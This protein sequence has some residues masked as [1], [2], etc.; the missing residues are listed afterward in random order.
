MSEDSQD[1]SAP[2]GP[3]RPEGETPAQPAMPA[4]QGES[5]AAKPAPQPAGE[6]SGA[7]PVPAAAGDAA[8]KPA[9]PAPASPTADT[10]SSE[11]AAPAPAPRPRPAPPAAGA[12]AAAAPAAPAAAGEAAAPR[13]PRAPAGPS[14]AELA[15]RAE[16]PS[17][18]LD[19]LRAKFP[20]IAKSATFFAGVPIVEVPAASIVEVCRFLKEDPEASCKY[21]SNLHGNHNPDLPKPLEVIYNLYSI[22][23]AQWIEL[24]TALA[25]G[26]EIATVSTV[27]PTANW[28]EREAFDL[29]GIRFAGHPDLTRILL[30]DDWVGHPLRKEYP[31]EGKE[32]DHRT[33]R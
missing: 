1:K 2:E 28:H 31:L 33:Y 29:L 11:G 32:G 26:E 18:A 24:K 10:P 9:A 16:V 5:A 30:P 8:A 21:L 17:T 25:G 15:Q 13:A 27:W 19:R 6:D 7:K 23:T 20:E 3:K 4:T 22:R 14:P 12:P